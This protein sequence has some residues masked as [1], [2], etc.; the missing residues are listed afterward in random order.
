MY[1][2]VYRFA[3]DNNE[4]ENLLCLPNQKTNGTMIVPETKR[5]L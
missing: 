5:E 2:S 4:S 3:E 1:D